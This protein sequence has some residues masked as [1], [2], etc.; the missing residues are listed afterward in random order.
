[1][2]LIFPERLKLL[3]TTKHL[4]QKD[5]AKLLD[6]TTSAYGFYEQGKRTPD[7]AALIQ[8][9]DFFD[10]SVDYLLGRTDQPK[11]NIPSIEKEA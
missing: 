11:P 9:A 6:I 3:R 5:L 8:L 1:M 7:S 2:L 4:L 10:V